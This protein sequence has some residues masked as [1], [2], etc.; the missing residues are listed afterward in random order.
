MTNRRRDPARGP[1]GMQP[2]GQHSTSSPDAGPSRGRARR[3]L[4]RLVVTPTFTAGTCIVF[5]AVLAYGTTQTHMAFRRLGPP[6][7]GA[8]CSGRRPRPRRGGAAPQGRGTGRDGNERPFAP[9]RRS[10]APPGRSR[11]GTRIR[12]PA[13]WRGTCHRSPLR[14]A[15]RWSSPTG[16]CAAGT[17]GSPP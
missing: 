7:A 14:P 16:R 5:A 9:P 1:R 6:C 10:G 17:A 11:T 2:A 4:G 13:S 3:S 12:A 8:S 15:C